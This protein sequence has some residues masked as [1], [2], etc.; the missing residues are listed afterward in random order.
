MRATPR[1]AMRERTTVGERRM[2]RIIVLV[3]A[4]AL[5]ACGART[6]A[7]RVEAGPQFWRPSATKDP[8]RIA[9]TLETRRVRSGLTTRP[10]HEVFITVNGQVAI[11]GAVPR[12]RGVE[13][14]GRAEGIAV[15]AIC[16][17]Q[18]IARATLQVTCVVLVANE[19]A[20]TLSFTAGT[21]APG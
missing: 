7:G 13:L 12:D 15:G 8:W 21:T 5:A 2:A 10:E 20:T 16:T 14:A 1:Q 6:A 3:L 11:Q 17:P 19:R 4:L 18:M 9:G